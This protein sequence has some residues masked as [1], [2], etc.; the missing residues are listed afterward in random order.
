[1]NGRYVILSN[2]YIYLGS[3]ACEIEIVKEFGAKKQETKKYFDDE[4]KKIIDSC[5][6]YYDNKKITP[7][8]PIIRSCNQK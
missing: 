2:D 6:V 7:N 1:M 3:D 4:A 5:H 8:Q